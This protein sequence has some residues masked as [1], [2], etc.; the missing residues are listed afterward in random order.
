[1][2]KKKTKKWNKCINKPLYTMNAAYS[3][4]KNQG[5]DKMHVV[6]QLKKEKNLNT[7]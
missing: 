7:F 6:D 4:N 2:Q 1:M 5:N 3:L